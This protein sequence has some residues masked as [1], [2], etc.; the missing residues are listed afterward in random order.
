MASA[1]DT[2]ERAVASEVVEL[3]RL[4]FETNEKFVVTNQS[5]RVL[6]GRLQGQMDYCFDAGKQSDLLDWWRNEL[7][8]FRDRM[9]VLAAESKVPLPGGQRVPILTEDRASRLLEPC[10]DEPDF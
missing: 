7:P 10:P 4:L 9:L 8:N 3:L 1:E 2:Q 5:M 6:L